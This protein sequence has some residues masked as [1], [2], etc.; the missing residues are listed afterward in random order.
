MNIFKI[1]A[2]F[3]LEGINKKF[4]KGKFILL[5]ISMAIA[6]TVK[7]DTL[8]LP[9]LPVQKITLSH[10]SVG[11]FV[12]ILGVTELEFGMSDQVKKKII[13]HKNK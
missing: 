8:K 3:A 6:V 10:E 11:T 2:Q 13:N 5:A 7:V 4:L 12:F 1:W 9:S